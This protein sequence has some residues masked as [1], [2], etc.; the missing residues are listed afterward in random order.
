MKMKL[1]L[2]SYFM[3]KINIIGCHV[4]LIFQTLNS[5]PIHLNDLALD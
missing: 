4:A 2:V 3:E 1:K 5:I